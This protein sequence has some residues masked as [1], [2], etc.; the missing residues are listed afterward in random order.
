MAFTESNNTL[1]EYK[2]QQVYIK[3]YSSKNKNG[4]IS[5]MSFFVKNCVY[6]PCSMKTTR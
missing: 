5:K 3:G 1:F 4:E 6:T 2:G